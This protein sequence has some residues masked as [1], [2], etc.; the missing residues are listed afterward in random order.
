MINTFWRKTGSLLVHWLGTTLMLL[1]KRLSVTNTHSHM[2]ACMHARMHA[3]AHTHVHTQPQDDESRSSGEASQ[4]TSPDR[5]QEPEVDFTQSTVQDLLQ[6]A[7]MISYTTPSTHHLDP[8][9]LSNYFIL[10][11]VGETPCI[12][13]LHQTSKFP[14]QIRTCVSL[15]PCLGMRLVPV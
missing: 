5:Q 10:H 4:A 8:R 2:H 15:V 13:C 3:H 6:Q 1:I 12:S 11:T 9:F 14:Y 7:F